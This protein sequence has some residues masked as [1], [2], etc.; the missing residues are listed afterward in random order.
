MQPQPSDLVLERLL[1][2]HPKAIDLSLGRIERLLD[3]LGHPENRLAP[4]VHV[5]G[6][7]GKGSTVAYMRAFLEAA[8][9]RVQ[10]YTSPHLVRFAER[11]RLSRG[12]VSDDELTAL[13]E[14]CERVNGGEPIT[15][16]EITTAAAFL[17]FA[18]EEADVLLLE[19]GLGGRLDAT[20]V[21]KRPA[22]SAITPVSIDHTQFLGNTLEAIAFEK[23]GILR[24]GV[25][26][27]IGPQLPGAMGVIEAQAERLGTPLYRFGVEWR[28]DPTS[29]GIRYE[30][31]RWRLDL[32]RPALLGAHQIFN[33]GVSIAAAE[34]LE[35]FH[36]TPAHLKAGLAN[37]EWPARL[38]RLV[39]GPL[40]NLLPEPAWEL[41]LDG[42]HNAA[43]GEILAAQASQWTDKPLALV[44]GM[45]KTKDAAHFLAPLAPYSTALRAVTIPGEVNSLPAEEACAY[46]RAAGHRAEVAD[47]VDAAVRELVATLDRP[48]R[49]LICGS[50]YL[51]GKVLAEN[52]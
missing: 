50:L 43:A 28:V 21:V 2:L 29:S 10:V 52:G 40:R 32:P 16:F 49:I 17:A 51:A 14:E 37:V 1:A 33:A 9:C 31:Q 39:L 5:A 45:L 25:V 19:V 3:R 8:G 46:A 44:Y 30:G 35:G 20:N 24:P 48:S 42:G 41:W 38:Q 11:I 26:A 6:T 12:L 27:A 23:A 22:V 7:N 18:R 34:R 47:T 13:L 15:F 36:M 4:A